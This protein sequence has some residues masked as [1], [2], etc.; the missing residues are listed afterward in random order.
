MA[1]ESNK[2]SKN[3]GSFTLEFELFLIQLKVKLNLKFKHLSIL[4]QAEKLGLKR[5]M[6][7]PLKA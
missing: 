3:T 1:S 4:T 2:F 6:V 5:M 7:L